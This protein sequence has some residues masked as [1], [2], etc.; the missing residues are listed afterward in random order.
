M[1]GFLRGKVTYA[2][3]VSTLALFLVLSGGAAYAATY[4]VSS[5]SQVGPNVVAGHKP[6]SGDHANVIAGSISAKDLAAASVTTSALAAGSVTAADIEGGLPC[7][8]S[9]DAG[10][11]GGFI[12]TTCGS[13]RLAENGPGVYCIQV[14][15]VTDV[16]AGINV[17]LDSGSGGW[18]VAYSSTNP[19]EVS[20]LGCA[21]NF[22]AAVTTYAAAH[23]AAAS[24][25]FSVLV[26]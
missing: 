24:E 14:P 7:A 17:T 12:N 23:G 9:V 8:F 3:V 26:Y 16:V 22:N 20:A 5:N 11:I 25:S 2:N 21:A 4:L 19:T 15:L 13:I 10:D 1:R 18:P 6:P